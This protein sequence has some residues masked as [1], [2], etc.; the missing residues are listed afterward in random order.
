MKFVHL[1]VLILLN[2]SHSSKIELP[3]YKSSSSYE[4]LNS[5]NTTIDDIDKSHFLTDL[6]IGSPSQS[7]SLQIEMSS[8]DISIINNN[9]NSKE[10]RRIL[11]TKT[12]NT[13]Q[14]VEEKD[15]NEQKAVD[16]AIINNK[17]IDLQFKSSKKLNSEKINP[18]SSGILGLSLGDINQKKIINFWSNYQKT[19]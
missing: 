12:S 8:E 11:S 10:K 13:F 1:I 5:I 6:K 7:I 19:N 14:I 9:K 17:N 2:I 16:K 15:T 4:N 3:L 18:D